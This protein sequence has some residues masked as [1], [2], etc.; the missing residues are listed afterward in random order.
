MGDEHDSVVVPADHPPLKPGLRG[1]VQQV[2]EDAR[3][4]FGWGSPGFYA[5]FVNRLATAARTSTGSK[6]LRAPFA[7]VYKPLYRRCTNVYGVKVGHTATIGRR[8]AIHHHMGVAI[9]P[10]AVIGDDCIIRQNVTIGMLR[11]ADRASVP[12]VGNRVDIGAGA[13]ILGK[14]C[15]GDDAV[16]GANAVVVRD[17][18]AGYTALGNPARIVRLPRRA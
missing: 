10:R 4:H 13:Q 17:V 9:H 12:V 8:T 6:A 14:V 16:I 1:L 2:R 5:I 11:P 18:P 7:L 3:A 15:I